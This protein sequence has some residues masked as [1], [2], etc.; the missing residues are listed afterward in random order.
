MKELVINRRVA[1][2]GMG[3]ISGCG[4]TVD[5]NWDA[6]V[7]AKSGVGLI[8]QFDT[9]EYPVKIAAE[10]K[11]F[12][13]SKY[14]EAKEARRLTKFI[15]FG[16]VAA[17]Q[18][19]E[20]SGLDLTDEK[21]LK[22]VGVSVGVGIGSLLSMQ[23]SSLSLDKRGYRAVSPFFI[24]Y[25]IANMAAGLVSIRHKLGG[26][27]ICPTTACTSGTHGIGEAFDYIRLGRATAMVAGGAESAICELGIAGFAV[28]KALSRDNDNPL[29]ASRPFDLN[30]SGFVMGEGAATLVL[31]DYE[32]AVARGAKIYAEVVGYGMS[33]DGY[34]ITSPA[35][36]GEGAQRCMQGALDDAGLKPNQIDYINAHGTSTK[37]NDLYESK[38]INAVFGDHA[39]KLAVSSTKGVTGHCLGA[40]GGVEAVFCVKALG[41]QVVPPT[42]NYETPDPDCTL[43]YVP[44]KSKKLNI[45]YAMSNSFGFGGTNGSIIFKKH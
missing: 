14:F 3:C 19:L 38:A 24:P 23:N 28:M 40:A 27:N 13:E 7:N 11:N 1:V 2:T 21:L 39:K 16:C 4:N 29:T 26:P 34:H 18:S 41:D 37:L 15:K 8:T 44:N 22:R 12:D 9:T 45:N 42:A 25:T 33:G 17:Q 10:V 20:D 32:H 5:E 6:V 36:E 35:P 43:D 31:E 30:R